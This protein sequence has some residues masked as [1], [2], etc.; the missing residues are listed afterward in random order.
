MRLGGS[1]GP[2]SSPI[3]LDDGLH[4]ARVGRRQRAV[5]ARP[6]SGTGTSRRS[7]YQLPQ[8]GFPVVGAARA[9]CCRQGGGR[10]RAG[11]CRAAGT[12]CTR[13]TAP[14]TR[15]RPRRASW[16]AP[17]R[18]PGPRPASARRGGSSSMT[19]SALVRAEHG[20]QRNR[21]GL[22]EPAQPVRLGRERLRPPRRRAAALTKTARPSASVPVRC[23]NPCRAPTSRTP[24]AATPAS[25]PTSA[26]KSSVMREV[27]RVIV[28]LIRR[29]TETAPVTDASDT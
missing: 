17:R 6:A 16:P 26:A 23:R 25:A 2:A 12:R 5:V 21:S 27:L 1:G 24:A 10:C 13:A 19:S 29:H 9:G 22:G 11:C 15:A 28:G 20:R 18:S 14:R 4:R 8:S 7:A 3:L